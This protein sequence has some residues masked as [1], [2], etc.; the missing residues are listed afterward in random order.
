MITDLGT[1]FHVGL[2]VQ[3]QADNLC[4]ALEA[5]Q[6][7]CCVTIGLNLC[8]DI[9]PHVQQQLHCRHMAIHGRQH[10]RRNAQ[11]T[12]SPERETREEIKIKS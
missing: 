5:S 6:G 11:L 8:I 10:E 2:P 7:Q 1:V 12:A 4:S 3:K 9:R